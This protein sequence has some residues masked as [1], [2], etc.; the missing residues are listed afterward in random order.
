MSAPRLVRSLKNLGQRT[1][2]DELPD[3][4]ADM[5]GIS[6]AKSD[7]D[8]YFVF[9]V[10][11][12]GA[13]KSA[14]HRA[15]VESGIFADGNYA[16]MNLDILLESIIPFRATSA[17][18]HAIKTFLGSDY[19][20]SKDI[21]KYSSI[22]GYGA[23]SSNVGA[24][25]FYN[26]E[27]TKIKLLRALAFKLAKEE[28]IPLLDAARKIL[29]MFKKFR[30]LILKLVPERE[31]VPSLLD[32]HK[33][34][35]TAAIKKRV[36]IVYETVFSNIDKFDKLYEPLVAAGYK[37]LII[38]I[39]DDPEHIS[40]KIRARQE[41]GMPYG[42]YPFYRFVPSSLEVVTKQIESLESSIGKIKDKIASGAYNK[43]LIHIETVQS[44]FDPSKL[45]EAVD[46]TFFEE[47]ENIMRAYDIEEFTPSPAV[48]PAAA[49]GAAAAPAAADAA[50]G[51]SRRSRRGG[52][53]RR[54]FTRRR[55]I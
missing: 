47:I 15:L 32:L 3:L 30:E 53:R 45:P 6:S 50:A 55:R 38:Y 17:L 10:G 13:G 5:Y 41:Y 44:R 9:L 11:V 48:M 25:D 27:I 28:D 36:N 31:V 22:T 23:K 19:P 14:G 40:K 51:S 2:A 54:R 43:D 4:V 8:P 24:L 29:K 20:R 49:A 37:I 34:A 39:K 1:K 33:E 42:E 26:S 21:K 35:L 18:S 46:M 16:T 12:P 52:A 7:D